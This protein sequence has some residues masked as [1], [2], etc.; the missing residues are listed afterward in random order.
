MCSSQAAHSSAANPIIYKGEGVICEIKA[1]LRFT[2]VELIMR[3][4]RHPSWCAAVCLVIKA[5]VEIIAVCAYVCVCNRWMWQCALFPGII[6]VERLMSLIILICICSNGPW[7]IL[8]T[9]TIMDLKRFLISSLF[10][11]CHMSLL[12]LMCFA[13]LLDGHVPSF[14]SPL[15][16]TDCSFLLQVFSV[17]HIATKI[18][19]RW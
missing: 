13:L 15:F 11:F 1:V 12:L 18:V 3:A 6:C 16:F 9:L 7:C 4:G 5:E 17:A 14:Y 19:R 10:I 8:W 2:R